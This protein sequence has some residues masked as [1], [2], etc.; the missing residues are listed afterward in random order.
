MSVVALLKT[1]ISLFLI[2]NLLFTDGWRMEKTT[3]ENE[4]LNRRFGVEKI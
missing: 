4:N 3:T 2:I 1:R